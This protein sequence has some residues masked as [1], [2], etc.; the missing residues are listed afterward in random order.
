MGPSED[1]VQAMIGMQSRLHAFLLTLL[2]DSQ[3]ADDV[4]QE[5]NLILCR[6]SDDF[7]EGTDFQAWAFQIARYQCMAYW[8]L[9]QRDRLVFDQETLESFA[10]EVEKK[11][12]DTDRRAIE[13][14]KCLETLPENQRVLIEKRY[15]GKKFAVKAI[16]EALGRTELSVSQTLHRVRGKLLQ[17][18]EAR[19]ASSA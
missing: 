5:T 13:L 17:C 14:R 8:Q 11:L 6:K 1:Y 12:A 9:R 18:V 7:A 15:S 3:A 10:L 16:A 2:A 19:I 4:L